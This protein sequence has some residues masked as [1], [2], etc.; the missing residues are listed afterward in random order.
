MFPKILKYLSG[1]AFTQTQANNCTVIYY[2]RQS[3]L[4]ANMWQNINV[5]GQNQ[6]TLLMA[7]MCSAVLNSFK[8]FSESKD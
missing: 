8:V 2:N 6:K 7:K 4:H 5:W 3:Q 1:H